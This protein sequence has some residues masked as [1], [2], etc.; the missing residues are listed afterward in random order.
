MRYAVALRAFRT[1]ADRLQAC[2]VPV[3]PVKGIALARW[4]YEDVAERPFLDVDLLV[5]RPAWKD[6]RRALLALGSAFYDSSELGELAVHIDGASIELHAEMGRREMTSLSVEEI[7]GRCSIDT[8]TFGIPVLRLDDVDHLLLVAINAVK[9]GFVFAREHIPR[10]LERFLVRV[11]P[12]ELVTRA[13]AAA[14]ATGLYCTAEWMAET[15]G[16]SR[17]RKLLAMLEP[18][19]RRWYVRAFRTVYRS[20][21]P[22]WQLALALGFTC[23][24]H[25]G[26]RLSAAGR[27]LGRYVA[28]RVGRVPS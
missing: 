3:V 27:V 28:R 11:Q 16:S 23:N 8:E 21:S 24:D 7:L 20:R 6:A 2:G 19:Q 1:A 15:H 17:W 22:P 13:R 26:A 14:F 18:P 4:L 12:E 5:P 10:D 25:L 9:D